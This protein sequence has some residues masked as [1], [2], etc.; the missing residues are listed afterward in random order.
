MM[1][2]KHIADKWELLVSIV[3]T[4]LIVQ[5]RLNLRWAV[6]HLHIKYEIDAI[7]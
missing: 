5:T 2:D 1:G 4:A 7:T 6:V 3:W